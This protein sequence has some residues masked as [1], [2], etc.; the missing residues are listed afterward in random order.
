MR[1]LRAVGVPYSPEQIAFAAEDARAHAKQI[2]QELTQ[3]GEQDVHIDSELVA[4]ISY[5]QRLGKPGQP[6]PSGGPG[7]VRVSMQGG[8]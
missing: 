1:A 5:L 3:G 2:T 6:P 4:L 7:G 8:E